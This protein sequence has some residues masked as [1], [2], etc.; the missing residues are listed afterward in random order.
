MTP[1]SATSSALA[2]L[3]RPTFRWLWVAGVGTNIGVWM[4]EIGAGWL[5][6]QHFADDPPRAAWYVSLLPAATTMP[7]LLL[8]LPAGTLADVL[9]RRRI[10]L[11]TQACMLLLALALTIAAWTGHAPPALLLLVTLGLGIGAAATNP[12]WQTAMTDLVPRDELPAASS[13]NSVSLNVSRAVGPAIGG[14]LIASLIHS[15]PPVIFAL[16]AAAIVAMLI[17]LARWNYAPP[18]RGVAREGFLVAIIAGLRYVRQSPPMLAVLIR[19]ASF[20]LFASSLWALMPVIARDHLHLHAGGYGL[21]MACMGTGAVLTTALLPALRARYSSNRLVLGASLLYA[22]ALTVI[23]TTHSPFA[24]VPAMIAAGAGWV[25]MVVILNVS[26]QTCTPAFIRGRALATYFTVFFGCMAL[27][28][29]AWGKVAQQ[30]S[31]PTALLIAAGGMT[32]ALVSLLR[33]RIAPPMTD[34]SGTDS[35]PDSSPI[36]NPETPPGQLPTMQRPQPLDLAP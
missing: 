24:G 23:A 26:A 18:R 7:M 5:M 11:A 27:G 17:V 22:S 10:M 20:V 3:R 15:G 4:H 32:L 6:A 16:R 30:T 31:I 14:V 1:P 29:P 21:L 9:D 19:T 34:D 12:A 2:P 36:P 25:T 28:S 13:L 35:G 8:S 33:W